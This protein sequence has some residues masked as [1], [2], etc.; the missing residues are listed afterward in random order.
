MVTRGG[1]LLP[2]R[3][4]RRR[5]RAD[6]AGAPRRRAD[7]VACCRYAGLLALDRSPRRL[8]GLNLRDRPHRRVSALAYAVEPRGSA[9]PPAGWSARPA[10]ASASPATSA[11]A[12]LDVV[13]GA[14]ASFGRRGAGRSSTPRPASAC[15]W[16]RR[17]SGS[18]PCTPRSRRPRI[19]IGSR[20]ASPSPTTTTSA[21]TSAPAQLWMD[22]A[23]SALVVTLGGGVVELASPCGYGGGGVGRA[24]APASASRSAAAPSS[25][26][27][28]AATSAAWGRPP[29]WTSTPR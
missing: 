6:R 19:R 17:A 11:G 15:R 23:G 25:T 9:S 12:V 29:P 1:A 28:W 5:R 22:D 20:S 4:P 26:C 7:T 27:W 2:R 16:G 24:S 8:V 14:G 13:A 21:S 10:P 3:R 18:G